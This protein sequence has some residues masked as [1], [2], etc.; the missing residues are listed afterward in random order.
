MSKFFI[1][2]KKRAAQGRRSNLTTTSASAT[3]GEQDFDGARA[4]SYRQ[5]DISRLEATKNFGSEGTKI[6]SIERA[7]SRV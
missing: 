4:K 1:F 7:I 5:D 2:W 6:I 3:S